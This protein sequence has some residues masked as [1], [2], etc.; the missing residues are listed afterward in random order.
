[1]KIV[2]MTHTLVHG[3]AVSNNVIA[4]KHLLE[5]SGYTSK[6]YACNVRGKFESGVYRYKDNMQL[7]E[8]DI[9]VY[10]M[11]IGCELND[12]AVSFRCRKLMIYHNI[13]PPD[14]F[15]YYNPEAEARCRQGLEQLHKMKDNFDYVIC[16]SEFNREDLLKIGFDE[17]KTVTMPLFIDTDSYKAEA[18]A[19]VVEKYNDGRKNILFVG[20]IAPNKKI[21]DVIRVFAHYKK[22]FDSDSRLI[23][24][25]NGTEGLYYNELCEYIRAIGVKDVVFTGHVEFS[26]LIAYY[27]S[28]DLFLCMS[29]HEGFCVPVIEAMFFEIPVIAYSAAALPYTMGNSGILA[30]SKEPSYVCELIKRVLEDEELYKFIVEEQKKQ[31]KKFEFRLQKDNYC[32]FL[33]WLIEQ[34]S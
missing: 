25:G 19:A 29:E 26:E 3:D 8:D 28:A 10:H 6:V 32:K 2:Q 16:D 33:K 11:S 30:D 20:R 12:A 23:I 1:M 14:Y 24:V 21:Q 18:D 34:F 7:S 4:I 9:L 31:I 17:K 27:K 5:E 13:T 15:E 22:Y